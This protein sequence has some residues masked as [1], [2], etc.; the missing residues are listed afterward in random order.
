MKVKWDAANVDGKNINGEWVRITNRSSRRVPLRGWWLR[1]SY[2]RGSLHGKKKG[3]GFQFPKTASIAPNGSL[4]VFA[5][6]GRNSSTKLHWGL[7]DPPF[8]NATVDRVRAGDGAYLFDPDGDVRSYLQYPCRFGNCHDS[9]AGKVDVRATFRGLEFVTIRNT[10]SQAI[11]LTE[12]EVESVPWFYEFARGTVL[13]P[14]Q[15]LILYIGKGPGRRNTLVKNW[16]WRIG[17]LADRKDAVTLR[18]P[19]GAPV[20][21]HSWG[22]VSCPGV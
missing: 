10:S 21:C 1:D 7:S 9:L 22:G 14:R 4:T 20:D 16:G 13:Q 18:N 12:Y 19:L 17:L 2:L 6:K 8:E 15:S 3:R 11:D 5:G